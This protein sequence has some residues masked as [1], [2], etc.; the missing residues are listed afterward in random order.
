M[1]NNN[2]YLNY[3]NQVKN[4]SSLINFEDLDLIIKELKKLKKNK[5]RL[6]FIG[7]GGSAGN[8]SHAVNDF[9]K[10]CSIESYAITDNV[11]ELTARTN[12]DGWLSIF[13]EWLKIS[14][15][16][17]NDAI[18]VLSVGGGNKEKKVSENIIEAIKLAKLKK[19]KVFGIVGRDGGYA[20]KNGDYVLLIP[21][22]DPKLVTPLA[23]SFQSI[24]WHCIVSSPELQ[25][26]KTKW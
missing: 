3:F 20:K 22:T 5:G 19:A 9:R 2:F 15:L 4:I 14:K 1:K 24:L 26:K 21:N 8:C 16:N 10:L 7:L 13:S 23:E 6:F 25:D 18:F 17:S 11:S 12:D